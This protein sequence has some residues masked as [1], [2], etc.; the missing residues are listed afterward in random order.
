MLGKAAPPPLLPPPFSLLLSL[1]LSL[2]RYAE[3]LFA[4]VIKKEIKAF[5]DRSR[6]LLDTSQSAGN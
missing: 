5:I 1:P 6:R 4:G 3:Q 2:S